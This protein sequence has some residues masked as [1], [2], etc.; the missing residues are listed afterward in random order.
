MQLTSLPATEATHVLSRTMLE[1][2]ARFGFQQI[3]VEEFPRARA[4]ASERMQHDVA[5]VETFVAVQRIQP[6]SSLCMKED[7]SIVALVAMLWLREAAVAEILAG[8]F[9]ACDLDPALLSRGAEVPAAGYGWGIAATTKAGG[10]AALSLGDAL[11]VGPFGPFDLF[12]RAVT[13]VGR[14]I[15]QKRAGC[16]PLRGPDDDIMFRP[17]LAASRRAA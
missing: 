16:V 5:S 15:S 7:G 17:A 1:I 14:H 2:G 13:A 8:R 3:A 4:I 9:D 10:Q 12:S 11:T 6:A